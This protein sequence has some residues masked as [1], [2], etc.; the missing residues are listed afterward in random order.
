V[1]EVVLLVAA[2][3]QVTGSALYSVI[4][5]GVGGLIGVIVLLALEGDGRSNTAF[6]LETVFILRRATVAKRVAYP[7]IC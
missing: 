5:N 2:G 6:L 1:V 7:N 4:G 3:S